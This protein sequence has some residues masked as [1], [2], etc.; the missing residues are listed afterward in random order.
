MNPV[1]TMLRAT[2]VAVGVL[3]A[4]PA[5]AQ[6]QNE[7]LLQGDFRKEGDRL[8][9]DCSSFKTVVGCAAT[10]LTD[11]PVHLSVGSI[12]P[13]NGFA[14]GPAFGMLSNGENWPMS[15]NADAVFAP[16]G[17]WRSGAYLKFR[18]T[19][20][21]A[22][23]VLPAG[24][25]TAATAADLIHPYSVYN[26]YAQAISLPTVSY[27]GLGQESSRADR[28]AFRMRQTIVGGNAIVPVGHGRLSALNLAL[29][30]EVNGRMV[31]VG[32]TSSDKAPS[33]ETLFTDATAPGLSEQPGFLQLGEGIRITPSVFDGGL[34]LNYLA[35]F[36]QFVATS[37]STATFRRWTVDLGHEVPIWSRSAPP[38]APEA[39]GPDE[40]PR[41]TDGRCP[42]VAPVRISGA[43]NRT[44]TV[45]FRLL[46]SKSVMS[47]GHVVPFYFQQ[48][49]G[50]SDINGNR[51][52][53]SYDDYRFRGPHVLLFQ[54]SFE[55]SIAGPVGV[56]VA[57]DQGRVFLQ[58]EKLGF[59][60]LRHTFAV[61]ASVR[62]GS[63]PL[64]RAS[65]AT[66]GPE[67]HHIIVTISTSLL[68]SSSRPSLY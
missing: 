36:Q 66:G 15:F 37:D 10:V 19:D 58:D 20:I 47:S 12:A 48:T 65:W 64:V 44:G 31:T 16:G 18:H 43:L 29:L 8:K 28:T 63:A 60:G 49:L 50:G 13:Q 30:G 39:Y 68:G 2:L 7:G 59:T 53:A 67:G 5:I 4:W 34:R 9:E 51:V 46:A 61:G 38:L 57:A 32:G 42:R 45:G 25:G 54:E 22:V 33:I 11:H 23:Q 41:A 17:A 52:L 14:F 26:V 62:A 24:S 6:Q 27:Y 3:A 55:H 1:T 40:C 56:W 21:P 35:Q